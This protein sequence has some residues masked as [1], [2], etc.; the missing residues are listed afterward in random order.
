MEWFE[1]FGFEINPYSK[2]DPYTI[3]LDKLVWNRT[4]LKDVRKKL[5]KFVEDIFNG[6][7]VGL[8]IFGPTASGKTWLIR[9][10]EKEI[11]SKK[12]G[13][14][15]IY[16]KIPKLDPTF[17]VI[18]RIAIEN[19]IEKYMKKLTDY[20]SKQEGQTNLDAWI[21]V[22]V[23]EDLAKCFQQISSKSPND[24]IAKRWLSGDKISSTELNAIKVSSS[25]DSDY[26]KF[27]MLKNLLK[28]LSKIFPS[29]IL[30]I[31]ELENASTRFAGQVSETLREI[32]DEFSEKF[33]LICAFTAQKL[34]EWYDIGY[35][36]SLERRLDYVMELDSLKKDAI[37]DFLGMHHKVYRKTDFEVKNDL[38][39]FNEKGAISLLEVSDTR[40]HYPGFFLPNCQ[41]IL[42]LAFDKKIKE[43]NAEFVKN[44]ADVLRF[45]R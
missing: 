24:F 26:K 40:F 33:G 39:P 21:K 25:L 18:Y 36:E 14:V 10:I 30:V 8:K 2:I 42:R 1:S 37:S 29:I 20:V 34:E 41:E 15:F 35:T 32:L 23:N 19:F 6:N 27:E 17:S 3:P 13:M 22:L 16:T 31:D 7:R 4:D 38:Y 43:I 5:D 9:I 44:H 11:L 12:D 45:R 28:Q